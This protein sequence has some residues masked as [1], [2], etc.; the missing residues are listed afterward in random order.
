MWD[1]WD[2]LL[3]LKHCI[4]ARMAMSVALERVLR[5]EVVPV[6]IDGAQAACGVLQ[7]VNDGWLSLVEYERL[8][9]LVAP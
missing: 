7:S 9:E 6:L 4:S 1:E 5:A 3:K 8:H 2:E